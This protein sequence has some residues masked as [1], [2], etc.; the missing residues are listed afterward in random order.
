MLTPESLT[1]EFMKKRFESNLQIQKNLHYKWTG[2]VLKNR[3]IITIRFKWGQTIQFSAYRLAWEIYF[4]EK[5]QNPLAV[6]S[7]CGFKFC[8][9]PKHLETFNVGSFVHTK[10]VFSKEQRSLFGKKGNEIRWGNRCAK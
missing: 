3:P 10:P 4:G 1:F 9:N 7:N 2:S 5:L 6:R 8:M